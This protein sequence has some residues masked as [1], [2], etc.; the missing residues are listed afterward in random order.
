LIDDSAIKSD[1]SF[2]E[3]IFNLKKEAHEDNA[4]KAPTLNPK[5][6]DVMKEVKYKLTW[7]NK[8]KKTNKV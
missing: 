7:L 4:I 8:T 1:S 3:K 5:R 6:T 2:G